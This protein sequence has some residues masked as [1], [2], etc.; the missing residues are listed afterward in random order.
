MLVT[1][2]SPPVLRNAVLP[3]AG[4]VS[5]AAWGALAWQ[6]HTAGAP[7][8]AMLATMA[9]AWAALGWAVWRAPRASAA[10]TLGFALGF[11][12]IAFFAVPVME[13][14]HHRFLWDG[15]RFAATGDP[16]A[17]PPQARFADETITP[18]FR[19][20]LDRINHPDVPTVYGPATQ[21]AFRAAHAIA[22]TRLWPWKLILLGAELAIFALLWGELSARSRLLLAWCPLAIF[23]TGFN[24]HP[25]ALALT[26]LV[27]AWRLGAGGRG[28]AAG[29]VL[30]A[31]VAAKI[32]AVLLAPFVLWR[33]G[34][35]AWV[36]AAGAVLVFYG[37]FWLRG[38][39]ADLA[40]LRAMAGEWEFNSSVHALVAA[41]AS[42]AIARAGCAVAFG[43]VWL[44]LFLRW[45]KS[46]V[47]APPPGA[48]VY[49]AFLLLSAVANPWYALWLWPFVAQ[50]PSVTGIAALAAVSLTYVTGLNLG[51]ATLGNFGHPAW[52][53][54]VEFGVIAVAALW[55]WRRKK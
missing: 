37:P 3:V 49:G 33:L 27:A 1:P 51:D 43:A 29:A 35:R 55:D 36:A 20:V 18:E 32:F 25:D 26:L 44:A 10:M 23:E 13:D 47:A 41:V 21:W 9:V 4:G 19:A 40:G 6:S 17:E 50:R 38:S 46:P 48:W 5:A 2:A 24:A 42:P 11:R 53:R 34:W 16:Y 52:L 45:T 30:G 28:I 31:A 15:Y 39:A 7:L 54:P 22:P 12:L 8:V 14:D